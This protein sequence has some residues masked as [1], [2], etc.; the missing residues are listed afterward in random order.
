LT[1]FVKFWIWAEKVENNQVQQGVVDSHPTE[2]TIKTQ[3]EV[4]AETVL[5]KS[6]LA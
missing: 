3:W 2:Y 5:M 4:I 6:L 1:N